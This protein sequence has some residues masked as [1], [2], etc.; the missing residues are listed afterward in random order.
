MGDDRQ[1]VE[2]DLAGLE[3]I[4]RPPLVAEQTVAEK[5]QHIESS[6]YQPCYLIRLISAELEGVEVSS[7]RI[8]QGAEKEIAQMA[9]PFLDTIGQLLPP[10]VRKKLEWTARAE[11]LWT[12]ASS[13]VLDGL[14]AMCGRC[15]VV[16]QRTTGYLEL[17][18]LLG[19][20][21]DVTVLGGRPG[22]GKSTLAQNIALSM[23][24]SDEQLAVLVLTVDMD[25]KVWNRRLVSQCLNEALSVIQARP[26]SESYERLTEGDQGLLA[27]I[28]VC[29]FSLHKFPTATDVANEAIRHMD[30]DCKRC[31]VIVD[32]LQVIPLPEGVSDANGDQYRMNFLREL[33]SRIRVGGSAEGAAVLAISEIRKDGHDSPTLEDLLGSA[34]LGYA[35]DAVVVLSHAEGEPTR[36]N[37]V[38]TIEVAVVKTRNGHLGRTSLQF[39]YD[40]YRFEDVVPVTAAAERSVAPGRRPNPNAT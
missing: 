13:S 31:L 7:E 14:E 15:H 26:L 37:C 22:T 18:R 32:Y 33:S 1:R 8:L 25:P 6:D 28:R 35:A 9:V 29:T 40:R 30:V 34:R 20:L 12:G 36:D 39:H 24:A 10:K 5:L 17:D 2:S 27:R 11:R 38:T 16:S 23:L 19:G 4:V 21:P 3:R